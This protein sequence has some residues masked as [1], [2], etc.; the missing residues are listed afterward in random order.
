MKNIENITDLKNID[1]VTDLKKIKNHGEIKI[2]GISEVV[3]G[4]YDDA[5]I[6]FREIQ[7]CIEVRE[8]SFESFS[9]KLIS[10]FKDPTSEYFLFKDKIDSY[11]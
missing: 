5:F 9:S 4:I 6:T 3:T 8:Y 10:S 11:C 2:N 1:N 7:D